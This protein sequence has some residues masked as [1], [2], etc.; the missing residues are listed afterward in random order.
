MN[1]QPGNTGQQSI[2]SGWS[3]TNTCSQTQVHK[4]TQEAVLACIHNYGK[5]L[6]RPVTACCAALGQ[7]PS[8]MLHAVLDK[9]TVHL[10]EMRH[11]L[12]NPKYKELWGKSYTKG[13]GRL[14]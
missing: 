11:L 10:M 14:A 13:L 2:P 7:Y 6:S 12:M 8:N 4:I 9:T 1:S 3:C 5:A